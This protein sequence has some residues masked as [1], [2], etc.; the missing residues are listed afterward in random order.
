MGNYFKLPLSA[1]FDNNKDADL[2]CTGTLEDRPPSL[3][4]LPVHGSG[5]PLFSSGSTSSPT[6]QVPIDEDGKEAVLE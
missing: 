5:Q 2:P 6:V 3:L 1:V 4:P